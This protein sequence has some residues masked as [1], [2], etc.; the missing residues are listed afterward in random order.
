MLMQQ[1]ANQHPFITGNRIHCLEV[2]DPGRLSPRT[3]VQSP[4][5]SLSIQE[6]DS[7]PAPRPRPRQRRR[8]A[9]N[10]PIFATLS[11][12]CVPLA[13][14]AVMPNMTARSPVPEAAAASTAN[15]GSLRPIGNQLPD[16]YPGIYPGEQIVYY[17]LSP[18]PGVKTAQQRDENGCIWN[19]GAGGTSLGVGYPALTETGVQLCEDSS[20]A[21]K[22][23]RARMIGNTFPRVDGANLEIVDIIDAASGRSIMPSLQNPGAHFVPAAVP[24]L[25]PEAA[26]SRPAPDALAQQS[27]PAPAPARTQVRQVASVQHTAQDDQMVSMSG[28][29]ERMVPLTD[30]DPAQDEMVPITG[31]PTPLRAIRPGQ[32][33]AAGRPLSANYRTQNSPSGSPLDPS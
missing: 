9:F 5:V 29:T 30:I 11:V 19:V 8:L 2:V 10:M 4:A 14:A 25:S 21:A 7:L 16:N 6:V 1:A 28:A 23:Y 12:V 32:P 3:Q 24:A 15:I 18:L 26:A 13:A 31:E 17:H 27:R 33:M 22:P 20:F